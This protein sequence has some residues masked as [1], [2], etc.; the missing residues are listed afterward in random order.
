[1]GRLG[2]LAPSADRVAPLTTIIDVSYRRS[3]DVDWLTRR[4]AT[5]LLREPTGYTTFTVDAVAK[6][7]D[8][9]RATVYYQFG[10]KTGLLEA[11]CDSLAMEG[12]MD[13]L[14][15]A[16][17]HPDPDAGLE[18]F[19]ASFGRFWGAERLVMRRLRALAALD[20]EVGEVI[21]A[22]DERRRQGV[23]VLVDRLT[24]KP[25][26]TG[27]PDVA[28]AVTVPQSMTSFETFDTFAGP[29]KEPADVVPLIARLLMGVLAEEPAS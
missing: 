21:T 16:F 10:S 2:L 9:A 15:Q 3:G 13:E 19:V 29:D 27:R 18:R 11:L 23:R 6:A 24:R 1:M 25:G 20:P 4:T 14:S 5:A 26:R 8:V 22:R 17:T 12:H 28:E 7:A